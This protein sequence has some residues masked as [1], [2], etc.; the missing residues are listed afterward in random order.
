MNFRLIGAALITAG[1]TCFGILTAAGQKREESILRQLL[2]SLCYMNCELEYRLT[3]LPELCRKTGERCRGVL[4]KCIFRLSEELERQICPDAGSCMR[5]ALA[6]LSGLPDSAGQCLQML[7][8]SLGEFNLTGQ[9]SQMETVR[10][11]CRRKLKKLECNRDTRL[12]SY[13][14]LGLCA[15]A[16][17]AVLL[18]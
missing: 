7:G 11:E 9:L 2:D 6:D 3:P 1:C 13:R 12:R 5:C 17:L 16:A 15:G 14:T 4:Q 8:R 18:V 10:E